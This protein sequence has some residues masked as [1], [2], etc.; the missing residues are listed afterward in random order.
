MTRSKRFFLGLLSG[1]GS[2]AANI[3]FT[4][5]SIPLALH[6][7]DK[8]HFGLWALAAQ[9][10]GYLSLIDLGMSAAMSRYIADHKDNVNGGDYGSHLLT[11]GL[12]FAIQGA[13]IA[14]VGVGFSWFAPQLF[15]IPPV[16]AGEFRGLLMLLAGMTGFSVAVRSIGSPLWAFQ[17]SDVV[18]N[19]STIGVLLSI[20]LLWFGFKSGWGV[21]GFAIA[22]FP[23]LLGIPVVYAWICQRNGYYPAAA[24]WGKPSLL[25]FKRIFHFGKDGLLINL[26]SQLTNASQIMIISRWVGL[27]AAATFAVSTKVYSMAMMVVGNPVAVSAPGLA[28]LYV[29]GELRRFVQRYWDLIALILAAS[30][31]VATG[32]VA[33]NR[34]FVSFWTHGTIIWPWVGDLIL[35][36]LIVLRNLNGCFIGLF[37]LTGDWRPVRNIYLME[38]LVFAPVAILLAKPYGLVGVLMAS[39]IAHLFVTTTLSARAATRILGSLGRVGKGLVA[40]LGLLAVAGAVGW[41]GAHA[42]VNPIAMLAVT[43]CL[44]LLAL[45]AIWHLILPEPIRIEIRSRIGTTTI[46]LKSRFGGWSKRPPHN[47]SRDNAPINSK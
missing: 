8:E 35:A 19:C 34:S 26:G 1:Y 2:I 37:G 46:R 23:A 38:G 25:I 31:L 43:A 5:A 47:H 22:Q 15:A 13:V 40:S 6:Y 9:I 41:A 30:T 12:V 10:N 39:L 36:I 42:S 32:L 21:I 14:G 45:M 16:L 20:A 33:G 27:D 17:R 18:S 4:M 29:R 7:L 11:G 3:V 28:E 44:S 24:R